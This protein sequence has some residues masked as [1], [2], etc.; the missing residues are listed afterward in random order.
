MSHTIPQSP[1]LKCVSSFVARTTIAENR[2]FTLKWYNFWPNT[3]L[4]K[5]FFF[6]RIKA[7]N[8]T[9]YHIIP[10]IVIPLL[11]YLWLCALKFKFLIIKY[12]KYRKNSSILFTVCTAKVLLWILVDVLFL[13]LN[14]LTD[15]KGLENIMEAKYHRKKKLLL[16]YTW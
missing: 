14:E 4:K 13:I 1:I 3:T 2:C 16:L 9:S 11:Y 10:M 15:P 5:R 6:V 12:C 8:R 7:H